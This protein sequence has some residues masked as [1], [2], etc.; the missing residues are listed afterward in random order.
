MV[1]KKQQ[2]YVVIWDD[3]ELITTRKGPFSSSEMA[4]AFW[5]G[6]NYVNDSAL[7]LLGIVNGQFVAEK[8]AHKEERKRVLKG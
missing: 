4:D 6:V 5:S 1:K 3:D 2:W 8:L 7:E